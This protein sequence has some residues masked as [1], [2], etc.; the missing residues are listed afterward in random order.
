MGDLNLKVE[1]GVYDAKGI[2]HPSV[3]VYLD[4]SSANSAQML[5]FKL[6]QKYPGNKNP[7]G[8]PPLPISQETFEVFDKNGNRFEWNAMK[9]LG[10]NGI[11]DSTF[12]IRF[13][14]GRSSNE[15]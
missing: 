1:G 9:T 15:V 2:W 10:E 5:L 4:L 14:D 12:S 7:R 13:W 8:G 6:K 3:T 11:V